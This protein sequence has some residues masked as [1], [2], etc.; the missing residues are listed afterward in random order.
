MSF[1]INKNQ[2]MVLEKLLDKYE[3]SKSY[4]DRNFIKQRFFIRPEDI[5][6]IYRD[7][8]A[9]VTQISDFEQDVQTLEREGLVKIILKNDEI[10]KIV[11]EEERI[12]EY[13]SILG[14]TEKKELISQEIALYQKFLGKSV[15]LDRFCR[16]QIRRLEKGNKPEVSKEKAENLLPLIQFILNNQDEFLERELSI[17]FFGNTK[18]FEKYY[19]ATACKIME[20][21]GNYQDRLFGVSDSREKELILLGE[22][23]IHANPSYIYLRGNG[24]FQL[25]NGTVLRLTPENPIAFSA[26]TIKNIDKLSIENA[27]VMTIENLASFHRIYEQD[28]FY[29]FLSGYHNTLKQ[30]FITRL[31]QENPKLRWY[32]FGDLDPDGYYIL[33]N[34]KRGTGISFEPFHMGVDD[35]VKFQMY[36]KKL[37]GSDQKK[38]KTLMNS[39]LYCKEL[40]YMLKEDVKLEQEIIAWELAGISFI[41]HQ[42]EGHVLN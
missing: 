41:D 15:L 22:H 9:D 11:A 28:T 25:K 7:S 2:R 20:K 35:L 13:Y 18:V 24:E 38:A 32:H 4:T 37:N 8:F 3:N 39:G 6:E 19:R 27:K 26:E 21:Y 40:S 29:I 42:A 36:G 30:Y 17:R 16:E 1:H 33:E 23:N 12:A 31:A 14:R 10:Q 5:C 34:L